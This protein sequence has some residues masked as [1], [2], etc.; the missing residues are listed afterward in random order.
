MIEKL[1]DWLMRTVPKIVLIGGTILAALYVAAWLLFELP[2]RRLEYLF[3]E[4]KVDWVTTSVMRQYAILVSQDRLYQGIVVVA[5]LGLLIWRWRTSS[6]EEECLAERQNDDECRT[7][8]KSRQNLS[9]ERQ[10]RYWEGY[11]EKNL[12]EGEDNSLTPR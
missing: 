7:C 4:S 5:G 3:P 10:N 11:F 1:T 12:I 8:P 2:I 9:F 6:H